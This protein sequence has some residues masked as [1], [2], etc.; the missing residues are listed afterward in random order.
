[1]DA[2]SPDIVSTALRPKFIFDPPYVDIPV[3]PILF[4]KQTLTNGSNQSNAEL[5]SFCVDEGGG[6]YSFRLQNQEQTG[7]WEFYIMVRAKLNNVVFSTLKYKLE[8][9]C[10]LLSTTLSLSATNTKQNSAILNDGTLS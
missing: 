2:L 5:T 8:V 3:C 6:K 1:M 9:K 4:T 7:V 10:G